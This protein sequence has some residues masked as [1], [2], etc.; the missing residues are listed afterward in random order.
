MFV[1][2]AHKCLSWLLSHDN[3]PEHS[4]PLEWLLRHQLSVLPN[5]PTEVS[6]HCLVRYC[7]TRQ[8]LNSFLLSMTLHSVTI[9]GTK[10]K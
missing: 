4:P 8:T 1:V 6:S 9:T 10:E 7:K 3:L 5:P 2:N